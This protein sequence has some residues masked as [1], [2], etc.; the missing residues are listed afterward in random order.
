M[1]ETYDSQGNIIY[2]PK[3]ERHRFT[4]GMTYDN[5]H[6]I[7]S[8]TQKHEW[9]EGTTSN[10][11]ATVEPTSYRLNYKYQD[12]SHPHAP[13]RIIDEPNVVPNATC[14]N[15]DDP[16]VKFQDYQYDPKGNPTKILQ[17]TC[18]NQEEKA[19]YLWDEENRLRFVDTNPTTPEA[20]GAAIYTYDAGGERIIKDVLFKGKIG[21]YNS[22]HI[23]V[24]GETIHEASIYPSGLITL[25][26]TYDL[27]N[28]M[29][30]EPSYTKHYYAGSQRIQS[31]NGN[32]G[33]VGA[34]DCA[35]L[36]IPFG[37]TTPPINP[38]N[39]SNQILQTATQSNLVIM[40]TNNLTPP[41]N[42]GQ[43]GGYT[44]N[45]VSSYASNVE[46]KEI[47][48]F[49]PD[50]LGSSSFI[51]GLDG[52]VTQNMEYFPSGEIFVENHYKD[53][54]NSQ[55][56]FNG[57]E[58][59]SETGYYYYGARYY[60]PRVSLWLNVDPLAESYML[61]QDYPEGLNSGTLNGY[62]YTFQNPVKY[63]DYEG[64]IPIPV[65]TGLIGGLINVGI[66]IWVQ[67]KEMEN[68]HEDFSWSKI[69]MARV[70]F[71]AGAGFVAGATGQWEVAAAASGVGNLGD[72][73]I[74][75]GWNMK[76]V[77]YITVAVSA[78]LGGAST[79]MGQAV[80][81]SK[82]VNGVV[83]P[84]ADRLTR[85]AAVSATSKYT[86]TL[87]EKTGET[88]ASSFVNRTTNSL[89]SAIGNGI[90]GYISTNPYLG[91]DYFRGWYQSSS[92]WIYN[93]KL[94]KNQRVSLNVGP[95]IKEGY[96][97]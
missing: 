10:N 88:A 62:A 84:I 11:W 12:P 41:V 22:N 89:G 96:E 73:L 82:V 16:G 64:A 47:Y 79:K 72:Q 97:R 29:L 50:H 32:S 25:K 91:R 28:G 65:I 85:N 87:W 36:I 34:F 94:H 6:N 57:K 19:V 24:S 55:Y 39:I 67:A 74:S 53:D 43:N 3:E 26:L 66:N 63:T 83:Y 92:R 60:N 61:Y 51:T 31:K 54:L 48:W 52:E 18:T 46:E 71:A 95:L 13:S 7:M 45:C 70:G 35:W 58:M 38:V 1:K 93:K 5:M 21:K 2:V 9:V 42:Y 44:G 49:H 80:V 56:K 17:Q 76:K 78:A 33:N 15:P 77:N 86:A 59:D 75:N 30:Q 40:Q 23:E 90:T 68:R 14:C 37:G 69:S 4:V 81:N 8:K 27:Q 20:D